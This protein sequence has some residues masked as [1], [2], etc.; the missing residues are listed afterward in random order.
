MAAVFSAFGIGFSDLAHE[1]RIPASGDIEALQESMLQ[2]ARRDMAGEGV[3]ASACSYTF[4]RWIVDDEAIEQRPFSPEDVVVGDVYLHL[5]AS[6]KLPVFHLAA[7]S[8]TRTSNPQ[9]SQRGQGGLP[10]YAVD[11]AAPG[12]SISGPALLR[13]NYLTC[14][15]DPG[16]SLRVTD[17]QDLIIERA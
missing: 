9:P 13:S 4:S 5:K 6:F 11:A 1:Y 7:D 3:D 16:W 8:G 12:S 15:V 14:L 2:R 10:I 17:N